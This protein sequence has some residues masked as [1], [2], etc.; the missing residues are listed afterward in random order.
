MLVDV[1]S[2]S[3]RP[4]TDPKNRSAPAGMDVPPRPLHSLFCVVLLDMTSCR[5][6]EC[7]D[8]SILCACVGGWGVYRFDDQLVELS[9]VK[10]EVAAMQLE[11]V[12]AMSNTVV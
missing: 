2:C 4:K 5:C 7:C 3:V 8:V 11:I 9:S 1:V 6:S 10:A 12:C